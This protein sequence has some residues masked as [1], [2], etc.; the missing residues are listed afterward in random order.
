[1]TQ[2]IRKLLQNVKTGCVSLDKKKSGHS[3]GKTH[4][5]WGM[6]ESAQELEALYSILTEL[7]RVNQRLGEEICPMM[8][9][10]FKK[11][12]K[13]VEISKDRSRFRRK[14]Y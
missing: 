10:F 3:L 14:K 9:I 8:C 7:E 5:I 12:P 4:E 13:C 11:T 6:A 2:L 1:M